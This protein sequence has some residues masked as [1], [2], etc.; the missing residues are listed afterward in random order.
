MNKKNTMKAIIAGILIAGSAVGADVKSLGEMNGFYRYTA[1]LGPLLEK[2]HR[3]TRIPAWMLETDFP[4][5]KRPYPVEIPF[6]DALSVVRL[7]GGW[8]DKKL[9]DDRRNDLNDLVFRD[10]AG[11]LHYRWELL[12]ARLDPFIASGYTDLT[13]V[14][15]N[16][17]YCLAEKPVRGNFGQSAPPGD[18]NEWYAFIRDMCRELKRLY[19]EDIVKHFRFRMGTEMQDQRRFTGSQE[20]YFQYYDFAA[21]AVKE[22][23]PSAGFGPFNRAMPYSEEKKAEFPFAAVDILD[24]VKHCATGTNTATGQVG[25]PIDFVARSFYYFSSEP[26]PGVF[27]NIHPDQRTPEQGDLWR[28]A[29]AVA[30]SMEHISREVQEFGPHLQT[31]EKLCGLDTGVRGAAQTLHTIANLKEEGADR[32]WH[33]ELFEDVDADR[34]LMQGQGWLYSV[35]DHMR[36]GQLYTVPVKATPDN[37]NTQKALLS[38]KNDRAI[39]VVANWNVDREKHAANE[40]HLFIPHAVIPDH[41][42]SIRQISFTEETSVYDVLRRDFKAAGLLSKKHLDHRGAPATLAFRSYDMMAADRKAG[43]E[44]IKA[45]WNK[46]EQLMRGA[47]TLKTFSGTCKKS[48]G[49]E[50]VSF[51]AANPS[52]TVLVMDFKAQS[53]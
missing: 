11:A 43:T 53:N 29:R 24:L 12:K 3:L 23:I 13:L 45:N 21:K 39:L 25:S 19:G 31:E 26:Q 41:K 32:I 50:S 16:V 18:F 6:A 47:L 20:Q 4:Y 5:E 28:Q 14:M 2:G 10:D 38:V 37:G 40:L 36:G 35:L 46:Y 33:W 51:Q 44:F 22:E 34:T 9:Q 15:D 27:N 52:V 17:P 30:P 7:L 8:E 49:G 42:F 1:V 48:G